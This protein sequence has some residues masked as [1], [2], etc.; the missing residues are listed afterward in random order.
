MNFTSIHLIGYDLGAHVAGIAGKNTIRGRI[1]RI[2]GLDPSRPLFNENMSGNRLSIGDATMVEVYHSNGGQ[3]GIFTPIGNT[4]YY[5]NNGRVQAEC[6]STNNDCSH[7]RSV[8]TF[9][10]LLSGQN[11]YVIVPC[12]AVAEVAT[13]CSLDPIEIFLEELSPTGIYQINT[14]NAEAIKDQVETLN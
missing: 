10:R 14:V 9:S 1:Y 5:I 11:N 4:D 3:L 8:I 12:E 6:A 2:V 7:Y 13:G